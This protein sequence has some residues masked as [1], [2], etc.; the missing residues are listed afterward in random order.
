MGNICCF[1]SDELYFNSNISDLKTKLIEEYK[2]YLS[3]LKELKIN[4]NSTLNNC[5]NKSNNNNENNNENHSS[6]INKKYYYVPRNWFDNW[7]KRIETI[8]KTNKYKSF[9]FNF[10][11]KNDNN[12]QKFYYEIISDELWMQLYRNQMYNLDSVTRNY[13]NC[14]ICNNI[15]IIQ[16]TADKSNNI[17]IFFF[18]KEDDLFFTNLLFCFEKCENSQSECYALL[19]LL[20]KSPIQEILGN[21]KYDK[22]NEF[23]VKTNK[24][25]IYNKTRKID[26]EIKQFRER[27]YNKEFINKVQGPESFDNNED[28]K[29]YEIGNY[30]SS[31]KNKGLINLKKNFID[32]SVNGYDI[33]GVDGDINGGKNLISNAI[34]RNNSKTL[35]I[36]QKYNK[37]DN[38]KTKTF[39]LSLKNN[40]LISS[41]VEE[42]DYK[43]HSKKEEYSTN[44]EFNFK[45]INIFDYFD[46]NK[47]NESF[48]ESILYNLYNITEL[49]N[50]F[51][52]NKVISKNS[53]NSF[54]NEYLKILQFLNTNNN[55]NKIN[56]ICDNKENLLI[57]S[58]PYYNYQ[59]LLNLVIYQSSINIISKIIN[60][61]HLDLN[62]SINSE[63]NLQQSE[64]YDDEIYKNEEEEKNKKYEKFLKECQEN[65]NSNI[66]DMFYGIKEIKVICN[67]CNKSHYKYEIINL[68]EF[69]INNLHE[70]IKRKNIND[71]KNV[72][73]IIDCLNQFSEEKKQNGSLVIECNYC[74]EYQN[75]SLINK[76]CKYPKIFI[77]CF[78]YNNSSEYENEI[79]I[80]FE[81]KIQLKNDKYKL[82]GIISLQQKLNSN[83]ENDEYFTYCYSNQKWF[84][85]DRKRIIYIDFNINKKKIIPI[86]LFYQKL[87]E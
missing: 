42:I 44:N 69:S 15:I 2:L 30:C 8:Y 77:I 57:N 55:K 1:D 50:Y 51:L 83:V 25:I 46:E 28:Q 63:S 81:E 12:I 82:I 56:K 27:Q 70:Y 11:F 45:S 40:S 73:K 48:F 20:K 29:I 74:G 38:E 86:V 59:K 24:M 58:C 76:I 72:I 7:E 60:T 47:N 87:E 5:G 6:I 14:I 18:E 9:N 21:I 49:T 32:N 23:K 65:N 80:D 43:N 36:Y 78:Y 3:F 84:F 17:E 41:K 35:K 22:S 62:K 79:K 31:K 4:L 71:N 16:Y 85:Y 52:N 67:K 37:N 61:L 53:N 34:S 68:I 66:F 75:Y 19:N 54:F 33:S 64:S 39:I 13:K 26:E 10:E